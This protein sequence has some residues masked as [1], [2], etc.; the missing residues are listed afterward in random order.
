M[1]MLEVLPP[2]CIAKIG[3]QKFHF[4]YMFH[5]PACQEN[6]NILFL[7]HCHILIFHEKQA[8]DIS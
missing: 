1:D 8:I 2:C 4:L 5:N 3:H 6:M 7:K